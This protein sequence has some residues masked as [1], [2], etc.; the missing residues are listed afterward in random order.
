MAMI[1]CGADGETSGNAT[2]CNDNETCSQ[3]CTDDDNSC[4]MN[5]TDNATC[6]ATCRDG[7]EC[8]FA[9][10]NNA[11][12]D[13]DCSAGSCTVQGNSD[14]CGVTGSFTGIC[15]GTTNGECECG[16]VTDPGYGACI[17]AC[18]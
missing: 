11:V 16:D 2:N 9:C 1:G 14:S 12:C 10:N 4:S 5:C 8:S 13:F 17:A 18:S 6:D 3:D 7:Q 15:G